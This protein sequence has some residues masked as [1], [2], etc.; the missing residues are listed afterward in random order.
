LTF[1]GGRQE[2]WPAGVDLATAIKELT[3]APAT[4]ERV[5]LVVPAAQV[6]MRQ[7]Q[8]P[9]TG[10]QQLRDIL[11]LELK[12]ELAQD[13]ADLVFDALP[14]G[15]G[16]QLAFW[17]PQNA[18]AP[19]LAAAAA[20][21]C[22]AEIA[23]YAPACWGA[24]IPAADEK[25]TVALSDGSG[26]ALFVGGEPRFFR[27][28][29]GPLAEELPRTLTSLELGQGLTVDRCYLFGAASLFRADSAALPP[30]CSL[31]PTDGFL[32]ST[33]GSD[34]QVA[35]DLASL[36][37]VALVTETGEPL[38]FR[39][40]ALAYT[41]GRERLRKS[42]RVPA[43]LA[44]CIIIALF[45]EL[46]VRWQLL[47]RDLASLDR[48]VGAIY[49][50]VFPKRKPVDEAAEFK[51][52]IRRL[53]GS[54]GESSPLAALK[55]LADGLGEGISGCTEVEI[56]GQSIRLRGEG[57]SLQAVNELKGRLSQK[58]TGLDLV[59]SRSKGTGEVVFVLRATGLKG[60]AQ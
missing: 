30:V 42:L 43:I 54:S 21:G 47:R 28:F 48:T 49:K 19:L 2:E 39:Q 20:A 1:L 6:T 9:L 34:P 7:L 12:G 5:V 38:N 14:T 11:P 44:V 59:E 3:E 32:A 37:A 46:G 8:L 57:K 56:D 4:D 26:C 25:L 15:S 45:A 52:E 29:T 24:L 31:L 10:R 58:L 13:T 51:A 53:S 36:A 18:L 41:A 55:I 22:D 27:T 23:T 16:T 60:E 35:R 50:E 33:F 40:G 17:L